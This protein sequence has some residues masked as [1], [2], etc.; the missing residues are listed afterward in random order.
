MKRIAILGGTFDPIHQGHLA[1]AKHVLKQ[2][3]DEVWFMPALK[4][5]LKSR[6]LTSYSLRCSMIKRAIAPYR[7]MK[8]CTLEATLPTPSYTI[9]TVNALIKRYPKTCFSWV[10]GDDQYEQLDHWKD[11]EQ[12]KQKV[13][14]IC[15]H[16]G[17]P[18]LNKDD[19]MLW[20]KDF[21]VPISSTQI[22][23]G[24]WRL[25][26]PAVRKIMQQEGLYIQELLEHTLSEH[27][28]NHSISMTQVAITLAKAHHVDERKAYLAGMLH[29]IAKEMPK[30]EALRRMKILHPE[31]LEQSPKIWHQW[32]SEDF[33]RSA[34]L[35]HDQEICSAIAHHVMG[36]GK[37][38][39]AKIIYLADKIDPMRGYDIA[40]QLAVSLKDLNAGVA[41]VKSQQKHYLIQEG[42]HV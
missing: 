10:I 3:Q 22:R 25:T 18:P 2:G 17:K 4:T 15:F 40:H 35:I 38:K 5:P 7:K 34:L 29:D 28:R 11:W 21:D 20:V 30:E 31:Q 1:M 37:S 16:R 6:E 33:V 19:S 24:Q 36:D 9:N 8:L 13:Q 14:F 32:L 41:L 23:Q 42:V 26:V 27:R 39:L 12:L